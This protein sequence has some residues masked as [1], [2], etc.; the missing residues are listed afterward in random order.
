[1]VQEVTGYFK[2]KVFRTV[3]PRNVKLSEAPSYGIPINKYDPDCLGALS[4]KKLSEE[5]MKHV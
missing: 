3:I 4:Y 2:D 5:V 1:V